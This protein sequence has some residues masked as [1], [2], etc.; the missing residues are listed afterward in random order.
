MGEDPPVTGPLRLAELVAALSLATDLGTASPL[1][2]ALRTCLLS[3][4]LARRSGVG[5]DQ[6]A[7]V[8]YLALLRLVGCTADAADTAA[9]VGGDD[10]GFIGA[11]GPV[12]MGSTSEQLRTII[13][14]TGAGLPLP[15]RIGAVA[16]VLTDTK[17][18]QR[19][20]GEHCEA[21]QLLSARLGVS[22]D[23]TEALSL[24]Y[25]RWDGKGI[26]GHTAGTDVPA[27]VRVAVVARD[28]DLWVRSAG[29][30]I[31]VEVVRRR[32]GHAYDPTVA[33]A[34]GDDPHGVLSAANTD[35]VWEATLA[36]EPPPWVRV[37]EH[38]LEAALA[39]FADFTDLKSTWL[40]GHSRGVAALAAGAA[41]VAGRTSDEIRDLR[42][43]GLLHDVGRVG[44]PNGVWDTPGRLSIDAWEKVRLH[45]YL[46]ERV[47]SRSRRLAPLARLASCHHERS[48]RSGYHRGAAGADLSTA[49]RLLAAADS[50]HAMTENRPHRPA[51]SRDAACT[52]L[53]NAA[54]RGLHESVDVEAVVEA[55][56][57]PPQGVPARP[58]GLTDRELEVLRLI[59]RGRSNRQVATALV[60]SPKTV[61]THVEHIY[62]KVGVTTRA[63]A[64]LF[65]IEHDLL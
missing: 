54:R 16:T 52:E 24:A 23:V 30:E 6:L 22:A 50:Y 33:A 3:L 10:L 34:F 31:A 36:A 15:R 58:A 4:E 39:V 17:G 37:P 57:H 13:R 65:A 28:V 40:R 12:F 32:S 61:G 56:G 43:A 5:D 2:H 48:D 18:A 44:V 29:V 7:E 9:D 62:T 14:S 38:R 45:P 63:G 27:P 8:Y 26:P 35:D 1:E 42:C 53:R 20:I 64:A 55:A 51:L 46:T 19:S 25:E 59:A 41:A 11:L 49:E 60:I 21:A 47:L